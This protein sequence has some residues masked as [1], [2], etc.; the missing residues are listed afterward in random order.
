EGEDPNAEHIHKLQELI[1]ERKKSGGGRA[2][3][4]RAAAPVAAP[5]RGLAD[6]EAELADLPTSTELYTRLCHG[7]AAR[8]RGEEALAGRERARGRSPGGQLG[9]RELNLELLGLEVLAKRDAGAARTYLAG[10]RA[11]A[12]PGFAAIASD[13]TPAGLEYVRGLCLLAAGQRDTAQR[14]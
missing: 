11:G 4:K 7:L 8:A 6:L 2:R 12:A 14:A 1:D 13:D 5:D 9:A 10:S 3:D